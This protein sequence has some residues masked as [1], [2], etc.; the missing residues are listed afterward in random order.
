MR[1]FWVDRFVDFQSGK[2]S[3]SVKCISLAED[4]IHD[5]FRYVPIMPHS[6]VIEGIDQTGGIL[7]G[8]VNEYRDRVVLAKV[9][10]NFQRD[11]VDAMVAQ[12]PLVEVT[13][14]A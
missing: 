13:F 11:D 6:L 9:A 10:R 1:W 4:H 5:H 8:E 3:Q 12:S 14:E 7:V 2:F